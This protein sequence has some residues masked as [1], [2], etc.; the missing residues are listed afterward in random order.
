MQNYKGLWEISG[1][2]YGSIWIIRP[3]VYKA[4]RHWTQLINLLS[5]IKIKELSLKLAHFCRL[6][7]FLQSFRFRCCGTCALF[8]VRYKK[9]LLMIFLRLDLVLFATT[10]YGQKQS[11]N[12][13]YLKAESGIILQK[14]QKIFWYQMKLTD[15]FAK[16]RILFIFNERWKIISW[17][18]SIWINLL[19]E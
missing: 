8:D 2:D 4:T 12:T 6:Q 14:I 19:F 17:K 3:E 9:A 7:Y 11:L 15:V 10:K 18:I 1:Y 16:I 13:S 5:N